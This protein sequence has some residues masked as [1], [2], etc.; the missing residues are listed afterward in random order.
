MEP[1]SI[2]Y[3][4]C[5]PALSHP[6]AAMLPWRGCWAALVAVVSADGAWVTLAV[7]GAVSA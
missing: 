2:V 5:G 1:G 3:V 6:N 7:P 4:R